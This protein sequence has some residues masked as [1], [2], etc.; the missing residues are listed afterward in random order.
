MADKLIKIAKEFNV[1]TSTIVEY[2][3]GKGFDI[4]NKPTSMVSDDMYTELLKEY[5][6]SAEVKEKADKLVM[7]R[8]YA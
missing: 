2:L 3:N 1:G 6:S 8:T 4:Q 5:S 7:N